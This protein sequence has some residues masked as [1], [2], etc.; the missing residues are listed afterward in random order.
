MNTFSQ[1]TFNCSK[2]TIGTLEKGVEYVEIQQL[3]YYNDVSDVVLVFFMLTLK[4]ILHL[5]L[6]FLLVALNK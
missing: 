6:V 5:C 2:S 1:L 4:I 3:K